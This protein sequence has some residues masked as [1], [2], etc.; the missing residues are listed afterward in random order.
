MDELSER[1]DHIVRQ[2]RSQGYRLTPQRMAILR[3][4]VF[5]HAHPTAEEIHQQVVADFPMISLATVYK[6]LNVLKGIG[7]ILE[8]SVGGC[9][10]YDGQVTPHPHLICV[11]C[12]GIINLPPEAM[13]EMP[14][15]VL[16][17]TEFRALRYDLKVYGLCPRCQERGE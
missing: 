17:E 4:V 7:E 11:K 10:H 14:E 8:L 6:T 5:S 1:L 3:A 9:S 12:H 16:S 2:L 15:E 13:T